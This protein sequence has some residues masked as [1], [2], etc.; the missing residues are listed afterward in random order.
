MA[1]VVVTSLL[2]S[3]LSVH[4][5][6]PC[7]LCRRLVAG[8]HSY[9]KPEVYPDLCGGLQVVTNSVSVLGTEMYLLHV[10]LFA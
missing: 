2:Q 8:F 3:P 5:L 4:L 7:P 6:Y 10:H 9:V 1:V